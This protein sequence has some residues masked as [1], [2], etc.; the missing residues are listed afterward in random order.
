VEK[1]ATMGAAE[2]SVAMGTVLTSVATRDISS[3]GDPRLLLL[4]NNKKLKT[5][6]R[7]NHELIAQLA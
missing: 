5:C 1:V 2:A 3:Y 7:A 6:Q 4:K